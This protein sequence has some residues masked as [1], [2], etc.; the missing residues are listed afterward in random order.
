MKVDW[1]ALELIGIE[2]VWNCCYQNLSEA[3]PETKNE[4]KVIKEGCNRG[5]GLS[6]AI[7]LGTPESGF[8]HFCPRLTWIIGL[9]II[10]DAK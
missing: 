10:E 6:A 1:M 5:H 8:F 2:A 7:K 3:V 9:A 4:M